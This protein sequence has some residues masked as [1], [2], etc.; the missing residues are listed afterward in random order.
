MIKVIQRRVV[1]YGY[2]EETYIIS[3]FLVHYSV[4]GSFAYSLS[5]DPLYKPF[6]TS[7]MITS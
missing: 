4:P 7:L 1:S 2:G 6:C 5:E 3:G